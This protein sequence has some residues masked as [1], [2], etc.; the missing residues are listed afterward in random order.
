MPERGV[1]RPFGTPGPPCILVEVSHLLNRDIDALQLYQSKGGL[2]V[3]V[4]PLVAS[5]AKG[6]GES[7]NPDY[8]VCCGGNTI[9]SAPNFEVFHEDSLSQDENFEILQ[10][11]QAQDFAQ[12]IAVVT[13]HGDWL[14]NDLQLIMDLED[15]MDGFQR[16]T[17][18]PN[19]V[20]VDSFE[21]SYF[22]KHKCTPQ[23]VYF[24]VSLYAS[25][26]GNVS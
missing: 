11:V 16:Y 20:Q 22:T 5:I 23:L 9:L 10:Q 12:Y 2:L 14:V 3:H 19:I 24:W 13:D 25:V 1:C 4:T 8:V 21:P 15:A 6:I 17:G 7:Y 18:N 26:K